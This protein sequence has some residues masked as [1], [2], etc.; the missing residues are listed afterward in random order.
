MKACSN[1]QSIEVTPHYAWGATRHVLA[2]RCDACGHIET[3]EAEAPAF[4]PEPVS[5]FDA[6]E[7]VTPAEEPTEDAAPSRRKTRGAE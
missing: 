6:S 1:C 4:V 2:Q 7:A 5:E 3:P